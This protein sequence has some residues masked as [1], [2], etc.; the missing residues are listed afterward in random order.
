MK[1]RIGNVLYYPYLS[2][3]DS[4]GKSAEINMAVLS[5]R[6]EWQL[7]SDDRVRLKGQTQSIPMSVI[8]H[9]TRYFR[10]FA[11]TAPQRLPS[12]ASEPWASF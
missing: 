11:K 10:D 12:G 6:Y 2:T 8:K 1:F 4:R 3:K 5:D 7:G 9:L